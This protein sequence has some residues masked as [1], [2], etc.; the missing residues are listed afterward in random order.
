MAIRFHATQSLAGRA[1]SG[2][3]ARVVP[4][5]SILHRTSVAKFG[6]GSGH[7]ILSRHDDRMAH[8]SAGVRQRDGTLLS[9]AVHISA[10][11]VEWWRTVGSRLGAPGA[12]IR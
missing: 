2:I 4:E 12:E 10:E 9:I 7:R 8:G 1:D 3:S 6:A 5:R 11:E